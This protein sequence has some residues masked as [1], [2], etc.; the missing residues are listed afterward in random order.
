KVL[1]CCS[2][3]SLESWWVDKEIEKALAKEQEIWTTSGKKI[4]SIIPLNLDGF[5]LGGWVSGKASLIRSRSAADFI[6]WRDH[7]AFERQIFKLEQALRKDRGLG[8]HP[9][10]SRLHP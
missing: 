5:V 3:A 9:F 4:L 8:D 1:L 6:N 10:E 2:K 7:S